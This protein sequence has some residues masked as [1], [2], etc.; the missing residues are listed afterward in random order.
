M[1][2]FSKNK[3]YQEI[4]LVI[5]RIDIF[6]INAIKRFKNIPKSER[7]SKLN[8]MKDEKIEKVIDIL[9]VNRANIHFID[10]YHDDENENEDDEVDY[11]NNKNNL[12]IDYLN[13]RQ[14]IIF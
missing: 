7:I 10:N 12:E 4:H 1:I 13:F 6:E 9:G 8:L 14:Y 11:K 5:T 2:N 3:G